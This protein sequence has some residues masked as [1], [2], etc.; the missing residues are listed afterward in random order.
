M[1]TW[2][3]PRTNTVESDFVDHDWVVPEAME[4]DE[5]AESDQQVFAAEELKQKRIR[6][7]VK[8]QRLHNLCN[9]RF[10]AS[11]LNFTNSCKSFMFHFGPRAKSL[12]LFVNQF[13]CALLE[14]RFQKFNHFLFS[15]YLQGRV[16]YLVKW[17]G[18]TPK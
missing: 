18:W 9:Y 13:G 14:K 5:Q 16:E 10:T 3:S 11:L 8:N 15:I 17:K 4:E 6:K 1:D 7:V 12:G 2:S